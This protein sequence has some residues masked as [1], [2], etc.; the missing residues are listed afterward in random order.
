MRKTRFLDPVT[1]TFV[2]P[3]PKYLRTDHLLEIYDK[4]VPAAVQ[5]KTSGIGML[6]Q[7]RSC[8]ASHVLYILH[9]WAV[10]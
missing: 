7:E 4:A 5:K 3:I 6:F 10:G 1:A 2:Y 9:D 8:Y